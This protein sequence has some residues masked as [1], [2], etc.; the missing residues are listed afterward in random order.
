MYTKILSARQSQS[1]E[2]RFFFFLL[3]CVC[4]RYSVFHQSFQLSQCFLDFR[5]C[6]RTVYQLPV[7]GV[8][9]EMKWVN[10]DS[11]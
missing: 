7:S 6:T 9:L 8:E 3:G 1:Y 5:Y 10:N 2:A 11:G 4:T